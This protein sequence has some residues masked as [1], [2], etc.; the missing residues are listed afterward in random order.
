VIDPRKVN[1]GRSERIWAM[2][3]ILCGA[4][5]GAQRG[6]AELECPGGPP[7]RA[8]CTR[9]DISAFVADSDLKRDD[10]AGGAK[11]GRRGGSTNS[12]AVVTILR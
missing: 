9:W 12:L 3:A 10:C 4:I 6:R 7:K 8:L 5:R 11:Y 2:R 1:L